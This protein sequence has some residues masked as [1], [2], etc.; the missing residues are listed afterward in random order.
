MKQYQPN[1]LWY[2]ENLE[3][4]TF[5]VSVCDLSRVYPTSG[6]EAAGIGS[7]PPIPTLNWMKR[8]WKM[9]V[10][11]LCILWACIGMDMNDVPLIW[12]SQFPCPGPPA[13]YAADWQPP[14][15]SPQFVQDGCISASAPLVQWWCRNSWKEKKC[16][17]HKTWIGMS[18]KIF[19]WAFFY[20]IHCLKLSLLIAELLLKPTPFHGCILMC[21]T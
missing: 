12:A 13:G 20:C 10:W 6:P 2:E 5:K 9:D 15:L 14:S 7:S 11:Y 18:N 8:V 16:K 3:E 19:S 1:W 4:Y 21:V 17:E